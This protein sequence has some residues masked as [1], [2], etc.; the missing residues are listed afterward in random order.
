ML[1]KSNFIPKQ[2]NVI[3]SRLDH[4]G[5]YTCFD[6]SRIKLCG[7]QIKH[8]LQK[9]IDGAL[10]SMSDTSFISICTRWRFGK[11]GSSCKVGQQLKY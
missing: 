1:Q 4:S 6:I 11:K 10:Y 5:W 3:S 9:Q 2:L 8:D 7:C